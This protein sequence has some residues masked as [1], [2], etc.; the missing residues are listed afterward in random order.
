M[1][2]KLWI[3]LS[4]V[5]V[6]LSSI[7]LGGCKAQEPSQIEINETM[8]MIFNIA[9][10]MGKSLDYGMEMQGFT[11]EVDE[12]LQTDIYKFEN[13]DVVELFKSIGTQ[14]P[15]GYTQMDGFLTLAPEHVTG[16]LTLKGGPIKTY[17]FDN[18]AEVK[19][20]ANGYGCSYDTN[21]KK[22]KKTLKERLEEEEKS[23]K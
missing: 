5:L 7:V 12:A 19:I 9:Q 2:K 3:G 6:V 1:N 22:N 15:M 17:V 20:L 4:M 18:A 8:D 11:H 14:S 23:E 16:N 10:M 21:L 13:L